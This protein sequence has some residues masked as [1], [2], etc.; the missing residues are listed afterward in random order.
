M[1]NNSMNE[2]KLRQ[3]CCEG[4]LDLAQCLIA[5]GVD[6]NSHNKINGWT[7]LHWAS[8]RGHIGICKL[9]CS[10]GADKSVVNDQQKTPVDVAC[11]KT[12]HDLLSE[13]DSTWQR[14]AEKQGTGN[15][16]VPNYLTNPVFVHSLPPD[17]VQKQTQTRQ[18]SG[19]NMTKEFQPEVGGFLYQPDCVRLVGA[20]KFTPCGFPV[21]PDEL[22]LKVRIASGSN[23][24][25][26]EMSINRKSKITMEHFKYLLQQHFSESSF[27]INFIRKMPN[28]II[29][30]EQDISRLTDY[31][32]IEVVLAPDEQWKNTLF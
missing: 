16:F 30:C 3:A 11:N 27:K 29:Q 12:V 13:D 1:D 2:E 20:N 6:I 7:A 14:S 17:N 31:Q 9:L 24:D 28:T 4:N 26:T 32:E 5:A 8:K 21:H 22:I 25:F 10:A 15:S 18:I 23:L 19:I